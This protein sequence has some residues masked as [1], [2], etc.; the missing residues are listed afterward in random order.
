LSALVYSQTQTQ[1]ESAKDA[2]DAK[3]IGM[4][5]LRIRRLN[6]TKRLF[7]FISGVFSFAIF[8]FFALLR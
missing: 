5:S 4:S 1:R 7:C 3:E 2:K 6:F 8:A